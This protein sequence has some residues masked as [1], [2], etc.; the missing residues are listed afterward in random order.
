[1]KTGFFSKKISINFFNDIVFSIEKFVIGE[2]Y[3]LGGK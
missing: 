2:N 1:M 3:F